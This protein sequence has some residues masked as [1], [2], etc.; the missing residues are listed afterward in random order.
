MAGGR[1]LTTLIVAAGH[2]CVRVVD[3]RVVPLALRRGQSRTRRVD[4]QTSS[5]ARTKL[6]LYTVRARHDAPMKGDQRRCVDFL[7]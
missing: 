6:A 2:L 5:W 1:S 7:A 4:P 3:A